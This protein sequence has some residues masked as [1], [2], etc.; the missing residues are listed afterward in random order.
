MLWASCTDYVYALKNIV[1]VSLFSLF[2]L[3]LGKT[4]YNKC[5]FVT[6]IQ[7]S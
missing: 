6:E 2:V 7:N 3:K 5:Y 1:C 4:I